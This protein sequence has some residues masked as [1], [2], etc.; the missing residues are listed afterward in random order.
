MCHWVK[1]DMQT[2]NWKI[3]KTFA[4]EFV[5]STHNVR[6]NEVEVEKNS[7]NTFSIIESVVESIK[8]IIEFLFYIPHGYVG[9]HHIKSIS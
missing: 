6:L 8:I 3:N 4:C 1:N 7:N 9:D 2:F 5:V